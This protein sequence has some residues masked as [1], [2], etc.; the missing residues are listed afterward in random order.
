MLHIDCLQALLIINISV[1]LS[2]LGVC[3]W[4]KM[5]LVNFLVLTFSWK[6]MVFGW[7][8][9]LFG[10]FVLCV[11]SCVSSDSSLL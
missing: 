7:G 3:G 5:T 2:L 9:F 4:Q 1:V 6:I 11:V 8:L 10:F